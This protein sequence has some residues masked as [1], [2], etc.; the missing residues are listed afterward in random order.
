M[1]GYL[2]EQK[3]I[4]Q[5]DIVIDGHNS[6]TATIIALK[7]KED[8]TFEFSF[9]AID[10]WGVQSAPA[11]LTITVKNI[12]QAPIPNAGMDKTASSGDRVNGT[13]TM[14]GLILYWNV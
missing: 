12:N 1:L 9:Q 4:S 3:T 8:T 6:T 5:H 11:T 7:I 13:Q 2:W 10:N 14:A